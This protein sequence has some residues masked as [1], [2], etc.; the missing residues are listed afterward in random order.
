MDSFYTIILI[1]AAITL[2]IFLTVFGLLIQKTP[3]NAIYP[4]S[5]LTCPDYWSLTSDSDGTEI[6]KPHPSLN[7]GK[8]ISTDNT[9]GLQVSG[10]NTGSIN[11]TDASWSS[12]FMSNTK[13]AH[14]KWSLLHDITWDGVSN[15]NSC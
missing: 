11:F 13:C 10:E 3:T 8:D 14:H 6:C 9:P 2:I 7:T 15:Y 12:K 4:P 1:V 5:S